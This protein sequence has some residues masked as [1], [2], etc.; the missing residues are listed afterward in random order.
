M[1]LLSFGIMISRFTCVVVV[2]VIHL[3]P[4]SVLF[5]F[6]LMLNSILSYGYFT[7]CQSI[8]V[9]EY[10]CCFQFWVIVNNAAVSIHV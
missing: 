8:P 7:V 2:S 4:F 10:L 6:F 3:F 5:F 1:W 9:G